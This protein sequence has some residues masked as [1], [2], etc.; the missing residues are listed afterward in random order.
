MKSRQLP[1]ELPNLGWLKYFNFFTKKNMNKCI[2]HIA[3]TGE[4]YG[5]ENFLS[6]ISCFGRAHIT[7]QNTHVHNSKC[8]KSAVPEVKTSEVPT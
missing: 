5:T 2:K 6:I 8:R 1:E 7:V 3:N 4:L